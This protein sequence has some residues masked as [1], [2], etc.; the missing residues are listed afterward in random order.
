MKALQMRDDA[1]VHWGWADTGSA[2]GN[3]ESHDWKRTQLG[4]KGGNRYGG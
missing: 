1:Q 2:L 3:F 4:L